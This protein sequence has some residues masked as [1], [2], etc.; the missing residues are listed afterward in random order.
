M[1]KVWNMLVVVVGFVVGLFS[2]KESGFTTKISVFFKGK[3]CER[4]MMICREYRF[5][6][7]TYF[8]DQLFSTHLFSF[9]GGLKRGFEIM[10]AVLSTWR[11]PSLKIQERMFRQIISRQIEFALD[12]ELNCIRDLKDRLRRTIS[13]TSVVLVRKDA[14]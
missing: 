13:Q 8:A 14:A 5:N 3:S 2:R 10:Y 11:S 7:E 6:G 9:R 1:S 4:L 12:N